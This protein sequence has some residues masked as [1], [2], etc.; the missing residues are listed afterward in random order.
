MLI[1]IEQISMIR[2]FK[3]LGQGGNVKR[4]SVIEN[5]KHV[6]QPPGEAAS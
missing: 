5:R 2:Y 3:I 4:S 6:K 1:D